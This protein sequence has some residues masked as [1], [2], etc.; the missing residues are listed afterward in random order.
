L[1][2]RTLDLVRNLRETEQLQAARRLAD[3]EQ[4]RQKAEAQ[5]VF[6]SRHADAMAARTERWL[7]QD[8]GCPAFLLQGVQEFSHAM[9]LAE[10]IQQSRSEVVTALVETRRTQWHASYLR[11]QQVDALLKWQGQV[12]QKAS[13]AQEKREQDALTGRQPLGG[14]KAR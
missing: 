7:G 11:S 6:F 5:Q 10:H 12:Q 13:D 8:I 4:Q 2:P 3:A 1:K 14:S 9:A